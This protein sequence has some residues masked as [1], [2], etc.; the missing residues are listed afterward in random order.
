MSPYLC[1][2]HVCSPPP[3]T[4]GSLAGPSEVLCLHGLH[5]LKLPSSCFHTEVPKSY[6][7]PEQETLL[8]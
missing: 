7:T 3:F 5:F 4:A 2:T 8:S 6:G 1:E